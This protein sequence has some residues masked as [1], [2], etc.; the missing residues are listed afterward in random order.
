MNINEKT[1]PIYPILYFSLVLVTLIVCFFLLF[2]HKVF[3]RIGFGIVLVI[4]IIENTIVLLKWVK[5]TGKLKGVL[6]N[7]DDFLP[8]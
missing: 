2:V 3:F 7:L 8:A 1:K 5:K 6:E 4:Q